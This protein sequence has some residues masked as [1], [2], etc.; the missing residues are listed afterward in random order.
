MVT[1]SCGASH[2]PSTYDSPKPSEPSRST[3]AHIR[4]SCTVMS[5]GRSPPTRM[6]AWPRIST[7][8][9]R[10]RRWANVDSSLVPVSATLAN[11]GDL[12]HGIDDAGHRQAR[13][14]EHP[15]K[16]L[17][18]RAAR[19]LVR[20]RLG[21]RPRGP[22]ATRAA[23]ELEQLMHATEVREERMRAQPG[24]IVAAVED[25][26]RREPAREYRRQDA[27]GRQRVREAERIADEIGA[28][29]I[30]AVEVRRVVQE[31][32]VALD[33]LDVGLGRQVRAD[34]LLGVRPHIA[35][36]RRVERAAADVE[37]VAL[38]DVPAV[39]GDVVEQHELGLAVV[40]EA[41]LGDRDRIGR[42]LELLHA[43][44]TT[45]PRRIEHARDRAV[46]AAR[47]DEVLR[48]EAADEPD[49]VAPLDRL[50]GRTEVQL[51]AALRQQPLI[52]LDAPDE[53]ALAAQRVLAAAERDVARV[54]LPQAARIA[55]RRDANDIPER[56]RQP[57]RAQLHAREL[58]PVAHGDPRSRAN[59]R[60]RARAASRTTAHDDRVVHGAHLNTTR[61]AARH[62]FVMNRPRYG[63]API[64]PLIADRP[65]PKASVPRSSTE[66]SLWNTSWRIATFSLTNTCPCSMPRWISTMSPGSWGLVPPW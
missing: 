40:A 18:H 3:R 6:S 20:L 23:R 21:I 62:R 48:G 34:L 9:S 61:R 4:S 32:R 47:A 51:G 58:R 11:T 2:Q 50:H 5:H 19:E 30:R 56:G 24:A 55:A 39:P 46:R 14:G 15:R 13:P 60:A 52:E 12:H 25:R 57:P 16:T 44:R 38:R 22:V 35:D 27:F 64:T 43:D 26:L 45:R 8:R 29:A 28:V 33:V 36:A 66:P 42:Q 54:P 49:A 63:V 65:S 59:Q 53:P 17:C 1:S 41:R 10:A 7:H 31:V 37:P